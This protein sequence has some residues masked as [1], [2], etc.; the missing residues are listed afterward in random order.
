M[1]RTEKSSAATTDGRTIA[2]YTIWV[3]VPG[4]NQKDVKNS[5]KKEEQ[6]GLTQTLRNRNWRIIVFCIVWIL[7]NHCHFFWRTLS[8]QRWFI[9]KMVREMK[10]WNK[11]NL[12]YINENTYRRRRRSTLSLGNWNGYG[13]C[14]VYIPKT[15]GLW[16]GPYGR[17][18][19]PIFR[20]IQ[21]LNEAM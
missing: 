15:V 3:V 19:R 8:P 9:W 7:I 5:G 6:V 11:D 2:T 21:I 12:Q 20:Q 14:H 16:P 4:S 13:K 10:Q 17:H 18:L 1:T